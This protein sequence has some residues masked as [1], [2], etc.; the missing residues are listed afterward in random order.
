MNKNILKNIIIFITLL[1]SV[2]A[3]IFYF[4]LKAYTDELNR[5]YGD[6]MGWE[7]GIIELLEDMKNN[8]SEYN[9]DLYMNKNL[10]ESVSTISKNIDSDIPMEQ[11][12]AKM[13]AKEVKDNY[14]SHIQEYADI[15]E[16][17]I[18]NRQGNNF[19][20]KVM[21][22]YNTFYNNSII[23]PKTG[24][25]IGNAL[26]SNLSLEEFQDK[27]IEDGAIHYGIS[28][29]DFIND[30]QKMQRVNNISAVYS[31]AKQVYNQEFEKAANK[32]QTDK[33]SSIKQRWGSIKEEFK[34]NTKF[35]NS[36]PDA[37][38][39]LDGIK[40]WDGESRANAS[41]F[42]HSIPLKDLNKILTARGVNGY[43]E[44]V[45]IFSNPD[46]FKNV[47]AMISNISQ[48]NDTFSPISSDVLPSILKQARAYKN[49]GLNS[50]VKNNPNIFNLGSNNVVYQ[51][52]QYGNKI[53]T[54]FIRNNY[55][56]KKINE[57]MGVL[58]KLAKL[59][60]MGNK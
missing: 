31:K 55:D 48:F 46:N 18:N 47:R 7:L 10:L 4:S 25:R 20:K 1:V 42:L 21:E 23:P 24:K 12:T 9:P 26:R 54:G 30:S 27:M 58:D 35:I 28:K 38:V 8:P 29:E 16:F 11:A 13:K 43:K 15:Q 40:T 57:I 36:L 50:T 37:N 59:E 6:V 45:E 49:L 2:Y 14:A 60:A 44:F 51:Y 56:V 33:L 32:I 34:G 53:D 52:D 22:E 3:G 41:A 17:V 19:R 5:V 39:I